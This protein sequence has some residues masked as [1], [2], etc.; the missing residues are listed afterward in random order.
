M[1]PSI[2]LRSALHGGTACAML[3]ACAAP[4]NLVDPTALAP[5]AE[6]LSKKT[7]EYTGTAQTFKVPAGV[8]SIGI[9]ATGG[10][11]G[12]GY[13]YSGSHSA[14]GGLAG[15]VKATI[16]VTPGQRLSIFVGGD[17]SHGGYNG[18]G[19]SEESYGIGGGASDVRQ[20]GDGLNDRVVVGAGGGGGGSDGSC[21][22]T[23]CGYSAGGPGGDGGGHVGAPGAN[24][25]GQG[26]GDGGGGGRRRAGGAG[27]AG[28]GSNCPGSSG[29]KG[30]GGAANADCGGAYGGGGGGGY[31]GGGAGGSGSTSGSSISVYADA[32]GGGGGGSSFAAP[33][34]TDVHMSKATVP[35]D[36]LV[37]IS[38]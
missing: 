38:W 5:R 36:G 24:G 26:A 37:V 1:A 16:A 30:A 2:L 21:L 35:G 28:G 33:D 9:T 13:G 19:I 11:G 22:Y 8:T 3:T 6:Q 12:A 17:G 20:G 29:K 31:Y 34:A 25:Q 18:G 27:G 15:R 23:T 32:G 14:P 4:Q 10:S 7:F